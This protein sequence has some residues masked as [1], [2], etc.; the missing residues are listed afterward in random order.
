M[1]KQKA[2]L[3]DLDGTL[4][5]PNGRKM[6]GEAQAECVNDLVREAIANLVRM[7]YDNHYDVVLVSGRFW[8]YRPHTVHWLRAND[9][10]WDELFMRNPSDQRPDQII[11]REIY[12]QYIE[13]FYDIEIVLDDRK[14]VCDM[15][16]ELGL[17]V[18]NVG[19]CRDF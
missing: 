8:T 18:A 13:P 3:C 17:L 6:Y 15:W 2:I 19:N 12:E 16:A 9:I 10:P 1:Q 14:K 4:A 7:Y 5:D 11:K